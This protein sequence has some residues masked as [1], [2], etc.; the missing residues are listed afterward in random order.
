MSKLWQNP[1]IKI[2]HLYLLNPA[3]KITRELDNYQ[4]IIDYPFSGTT[5][6]LMNLYLYNGR[7]PRKKNSTKFHFEKN[8]GKNTNN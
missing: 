6:P 4:L 5:D 1:E 3:N 7:D 2:G 8:F